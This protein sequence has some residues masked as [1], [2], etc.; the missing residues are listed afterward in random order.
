MPAEGKI[1][2]RDQKIYSLS[3]SEVTKRWEVTSEDGQVVATFSAPEN[4]YLSVEVFGG[5]VVVVQVSQQRNAYTI[6]YRADGRRAEIARNFVLYP[7]VADS[8]RIVFSV[9][10]EGLKVL[11]VQQ[12]TVKRYKT[13]DSTLLALYEDRVFIANRSWK[14]GPSIE[15]VDLLTAQSHYIPVPDWRVGVWGQSIEASVLENDLL[16][17]DSSGMIY[18]INTGSREF[19][20][21]L[22][23]GYPYSNLSIVF[24]PDRRLLIIYGADGFIRVWGVVPEGSPV[25]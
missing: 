15:V 13:S 17:V 3:R 18:V 5:E 21:K 1:F 19:I 8:K 20:H 7:I 10:Q 14:T 11:D 22:N 16:M 12:W 9:Y 2:G 24:S 6:A 23:S 4:A 25:R